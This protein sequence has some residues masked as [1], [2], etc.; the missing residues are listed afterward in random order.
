MTFTVTKELVYFFVCLLLLLMQVHQRRKLDK[1][2]KDLDHVTNTVMILF[3]GIKQQ[4]DEQKEKGIGN[5]V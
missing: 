1:I 4:T 3:F 2:K 5:G